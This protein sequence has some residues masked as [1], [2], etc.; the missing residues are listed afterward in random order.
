MI[1]CNNKKR[2]NKK[3][4]KNKNKNKQIEFGLHTKEERHQK[5]SNIMMQIVMENMNH[6]ISDEIRLAFTKW[7]NE[8]GDYEKDVFLPRYTRTLQIRLHD[9][10]SQQTHV[11]FKYNQV[12][13][14]GENINDMIK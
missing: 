4:K 1:K 9:D 11:C 3:N 7:I 12:M 6:V 5:I 10:K 2:N 14:E 8:G 13:I